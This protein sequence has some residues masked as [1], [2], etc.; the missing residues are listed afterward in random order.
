MLV[1]GG[2]TSGKPLFQ[3]MQLGT[4]LGPEG[5]ASATLLGL[6]KQQILL[7]YFDSSVSLKV[8]RVPPVF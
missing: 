5:T 3:R 6:D 1:Q 7:I 8:Y 4:L 2:N